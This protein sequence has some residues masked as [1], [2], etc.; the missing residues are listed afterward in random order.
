MCAPLLESHVARICF[1]FGRIVI[2]LNSY[3]KRWVKKGITKANI[4]KPEG[5]MHLPWAGM[6]KR[7]GNISKSRRAKSNAWLPINFF[8]QA[9]IVNPIIEKQEQ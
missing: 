6:K 3:F 8:L 4:Y 2:F 1:Y 7:F 5:A 9:T